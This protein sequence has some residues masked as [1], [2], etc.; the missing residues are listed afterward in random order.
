MEHRKHVVGAGL[1]RGV[2][3]QEKVPAVQSDQGRNLVHSTWTGRFQWSSAT[4]F[5]T[6]DRLNTR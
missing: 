1:E 3:V 2:G 4:C 6:R 5:G